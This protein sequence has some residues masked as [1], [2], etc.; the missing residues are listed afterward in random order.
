MKEQDCLER[1]MFAASENY[2]RIA[3]DFEDCSCA[4]GEESNDSPIFRVWDVG[5]LRFH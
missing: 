3:Y 5:S 1:A 4:E 2:S